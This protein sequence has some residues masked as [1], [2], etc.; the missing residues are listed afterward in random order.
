ML[1]KTE[2]LTLSSCLVWKWK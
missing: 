2:K 1:T